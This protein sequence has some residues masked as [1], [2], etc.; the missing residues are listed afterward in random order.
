MIVSN[1]M[2]IEW[3]VLVA[4]VALILSIQSWKRNYLGQKK[5]DI[6]EQT[7][8]LSYKL[9]DKIYDLR[10]PFESTKEQQSSIDK[11]KEKL[12]DPKF[13]NL[14]EEFYDKRL[15]YTALFGHINE[16]NFRSLN[17]LL[18]RFSSRLHHPILPDHFETIY[19]GI[20]GDEFSK[21]LEFSIKEIEQ[22]IHMLF[23]N[24]PKQFYIWLKNNS[25]TR[26]M[27]KK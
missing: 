8:I 14:L 7:L 20:D 19:S 27:G 2:N 15:H 9:R 3:E 21:E 11:K 12:Q 24:Y 1:E 6:A 16:A 5:L 22:N 18:N 17:S 10:N 26:K 25:Q 23:S 4:A 13:T